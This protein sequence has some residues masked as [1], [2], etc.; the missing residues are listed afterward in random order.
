MLRGQQLSTS[1][2]VL[3]TVGGTFTVILQKWEPEKLV[4]AEEKEAP[5]PTT[6]PFSQQQ[7]LYKQHL[8]YIQGEDASM[9]SKGSL[10]HLP[11][12]LSCW[13]PHGMEKVKPI[14]NTPPWALTSPNR[15]G[16]PLLGLDL[17]RR[18]ACDRAT[19]S[20]MGF[21]HVGQ[22]GLELL[23]SGETFELGLPK[24]WDYSFHIFVEMKLMTFQT[25]VKGTVAY[26]HNLST[27]EGQGG[28]ITR[29]G[30]RD[31]PDQH[32][33]QETNMGGSVEAR[34]SRPAWPTW[35][36]PVSTKNTK[37]SQAWW[38]MSAIPATRE[39]EAGELLEP[40]GTDCSEPRWRHCT[41]VWVTEQDCLKKKK[42][43]GERKT[44]F[45]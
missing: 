11:A 35:Q 5:P 1:A 26:A 41:L 36:N 30:V 38:R 45:K 44:Q 2:G 21:N 29:S 34:S 9:S 27:L 43:E 42:R 12:L 33:L 3:V 7:V 25:G 14:M 20:E 23:T 37:I 40:G 13:A 16:T 10:A 18:P 6:S 28:Q 4:I 17:F 32:V 8:A 31:Q 24:C 22:A 15:R 39:A 19:T